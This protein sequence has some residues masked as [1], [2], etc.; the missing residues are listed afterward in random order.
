MQEQITLLLGVQLRKFSFTC[1]KVFSK[2][3][4]T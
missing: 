3:S 4:N 1:C 2:R